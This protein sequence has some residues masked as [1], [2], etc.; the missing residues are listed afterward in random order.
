MVQR[1]DDIL[2]VIE[3]SLGTSSNDSRQLSYCVGCGTCAF[4]DK[5]FKIRM[6]DN[7]CFRA[8]YTEDG[9][10]ADLAL[11][12]SV[13]PFASTRDEDSLGKELYGSIEG[14]QHNE[15]L[16]YFL[17]SYIGSVRNSDDRMNSSSGGFTTWIAQACLRD[18]LVDKVIHVKESQEPGMM[19][20]YQISSTVEEIKAGARSK[21]YPIE[22]SKVLD[23]MKNN[24]GRYLVVGLPC[25]IK[26]LRLVADKDKV[27]KERLKF[28][29]GLVCGHLKSKFFA[30]AEAWETGVEPRD[31]EKVEFRK[32]INGNTAADYGIQ[33]ESSDDKSI[34][35]RV[36]DLSV[37]DWGKGYFKYN[38]CEYCDDILAETAD[39]CLG[40]AWLPNYV[41]DVKGMNIV[42]VRNPDIQALLDRHRDELEIVNANPDDIRK[43]QAGGFRHRRQGLQ[44][45]L[46]AQQDRGGW[47]PTKRVQPSYDMSERR[48]SIY[49]M[50][51]VLR[52]ESFVGFRKALNAD[53][54]SIF[55]SHMKPIELRYELIGKSKLKVLGKRVLPKGLKKILKRVLK[56]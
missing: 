46:K 40:D 25:F 26:G 10:D 32:K 19:Y 49:K 11:P 27:I 41:D 33:V 55:R 8:E 36:A 43:S 9:A 45:R 48:K 39:V 2:R 31:L 23:Y 56:R 22:L 15:Y 6:D 13:C 42:V 20:T 44:Y 47:I 54:Y 53:K 5:R 34:I 12:T 4:V 52:E 14:V 51:E 37:S 7:G 38:A 35:K 30:E 16:G 21:Y 29:V 28:C 1:S 18:G 24:E 17:G 50:R 3:G